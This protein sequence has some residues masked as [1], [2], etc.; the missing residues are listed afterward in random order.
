MQLVISGRIIQLWGF[1][2]PEGEPDKL[3]ERAFQHLFAAFLTGEVYDLDNFI[4]DVQPFF[5]THVGDAEAHN[6]FF[7]NV[8]SLWEILRGAGRDSEAEHVWSL[9]LVAAA[10]WEQ[11]NEEKVRIHK[12]IPFYFYGA[13]H[14]LHGDLD[15]GYSLMH[16]ALDED[17]RLYGVKPG[18]PL[19]PTPV[20]AFVALDW[21]EDVQ[22]FRQWIRNQATYIEERIAAYR[23]AH[24]SDLDASSFRKR[25]LERLTNADVL[26][27]FAYSVA[28]FMQF[29]DNRAKSP[30]PIG[31]NFVGQLE[32]G[33]CFDFLLVLDNAIKQQRRALPSTK[34]IALAT[35]VART[36]KLPI[37]TAELRELNGRFSGDRGGA[38]VELLDRK[39]R[40]NSRLLSPVEAD[41]A[42]AY[43]LR[44]DAAHDLCSIAALW[45]RFPEVEQS[46]FNTLFLVAEH[47]YSAPK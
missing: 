22:P 6:S 27:A 32:T 46:L 35:E 10:R 23:S 2:S 18:E 11:G 31:N 3:T 25:F 17:M 39:I 7:N 12:G 24:G 26:N 9:A 40:V 15:F 44:N 29:R 38:L 8:R 13:H 45:Q 41:I 20:R 33:M 14:L 37:T 43:V 28:R 36:L 30:Y 21:T 1:L 4:E 5:G 47:L 19:P 34:P 42:L 16:Q